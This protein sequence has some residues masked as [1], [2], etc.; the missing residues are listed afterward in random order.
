MLIQDSLTPYF[1]SYGVQ[2]LEDT[3]KGG[4][5]GG[6]LTKNIKHNK[7]GEVLVLFGGKGA[8]KSTFIKRLLH[9]NAPR[10]L[11]E[12]S[13]IAIV[14]LL[15]IPED[16]SVIRNFIWNT[17]LEQLDIDKLLDADRKNS[18]NIILR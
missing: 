8:G 7:K 3:G 15:K 13:S 6:R 17:I 14:D 9:H 11:K 4:R 2:Q 18:A 12:H 16:Q 5:L 10:W 1:E